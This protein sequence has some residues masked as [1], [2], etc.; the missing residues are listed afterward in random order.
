M[1]VDSF[2]LAVAKQTLR[3]KAR[4]ARYFE[5]RSRN[6]RYSMSAPEQLTAATDGAGLKIDPSA[7]QVVVGCDDNYACHLSVMLLSLFEHCRTL[8]VQVH[9]MVPPSFA[10]VAQLRQA[11]G[12]NA[13]RLIYHV[14]ADGSILRLKQREDLTAATYYR[15][16][17]SEV[18]PP[19]VH[20]I[21]YLDCDIMLRGDLAN[22]WC[23]P[24]SNAIVAAAPD[25]DFT[26]NHVLGLPDDAPYFNAGVLLVD[27][28]RW[29][30]EAIGQNA[31]AFAAAH[32]DRLT[33]ND[34]C[35]L[36]WVLRGR[37]RVLDPAWNLQTSAL[38][39]VV[40]GEIQYFNPIPSSATDARIVHFNAPGRPWLYMDD[41]PFKPDYLAYKA[42]TPWRG[43]RPVDRHARNIIIK[44]LRRHAPTLLSIYRSIR[45][46]V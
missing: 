18:L 10:S 27:L 35:A 1:K 21:L 7:M 31:L 17:M 11:L 33:Y 45:K 34:Q 37:W 36:N 5:L 16:L 23:L 22:L 38:S 19:S 9:V 32:P 30:S 44:T 43:E 2:C 13:G 46:Y 26:H 24:L 4:L 39:R 41:H 25:P 42:R 15:L 6:P 28:A 20:R 8:P 12:E 40:K 3:P 14:L 29:R